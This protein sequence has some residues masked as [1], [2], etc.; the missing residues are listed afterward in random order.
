MGHIFTLVLNRQLTGEEID[1]LRAA[2][3]QSATFGTDSLPT[4]ADVTVARLDFDDTES[5]SLAEAIQSAM[6]AVKTVPDLTIPGLTVPAVVR[7]DTDV[8]AGEV[9]DTAEREPVTAD[10]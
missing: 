5:P 6:D 8:V 10:L 3:C 7:A 1:S 4:N 9:V 2:G